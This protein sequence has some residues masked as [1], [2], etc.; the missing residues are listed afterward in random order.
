MEEHKYTFMEVNS[1][2]ERS[3]DRYGDFKS[4]HEAIGVALE[5]WDELRSAMHDND[6]EDVRAE[7]IDLAAVLIRLASQCRS[8]AGLKDRSVK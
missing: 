5:E 8:S 6:L 2:I 3:Q 7:A 1:H 4:V